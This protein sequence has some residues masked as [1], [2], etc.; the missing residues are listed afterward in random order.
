M[1][2]PD[3]TNGANTTWSNAILPKVMAILFCGNN[4]L[5]MGGN[6]LQYHTCKT[7]AIYNDPVKNKITFLFQSNELRFSIS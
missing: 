1:K 6:I 3:K 2:N 5:A 4:L 7:G